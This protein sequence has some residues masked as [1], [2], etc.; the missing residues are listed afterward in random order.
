M[1]ITL[2]QIT[3]IILVGAPTTEVTIQELINAIR[4]WE[5]ELENMDCAKVA[6]ASGKEDTG[7]AVYR[8]ICLKLSNWK[9]K[10]EAAAAPMV[11]TVSGGT[12]IAV[13]GNGYP[14]TPFEPSNNISYDRAKAVSGTIIPDVAEWTQAEKDV[15]LVDTPAIKNKT[16]NLPADPTSKSDLETEH[17]AGSWEGATPSQV[18][19]HT[20]RRLTS[21]DIE[22][23][24]PGESL[25]SEEQVQ[26]AQAALDTIKGLGFETAEDALRVIRQLVQA[27]GRRGASF[28]V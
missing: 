14:M 2:D 12:L 19:V 23:P 22:S 27:A 21:R 18:W 1:A 9:L 25:P 5:D 17:G 6:D 4:D 24:G 7:G 10:R 13:D 15:V 11:F 26:A 20:D 16:D 8:D 28:K 3:K